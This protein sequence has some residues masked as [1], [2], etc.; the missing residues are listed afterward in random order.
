[1]IHGYV[2]ILG[3][4]DGDKMTLCYIKVDL[5]WSGVGKPTF[6]SGRVNPVSW[7]FLSREVFFKGFF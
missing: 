1:M 3:S 5:S 6:L 4:P 2:G 7:V